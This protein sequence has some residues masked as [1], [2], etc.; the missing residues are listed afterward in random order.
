MDPGGVNLNGVFWPPVALDDAAEATGGQR[1]TPATWI[2]EPGGTLVKDF[3]KIFDDFRQG[4]VLR[5]TPTGVPLHGWHELNVALK[6]KGN[7]KV[8]ARRGYFG[9]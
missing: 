3:A 2:T 5:F 7:Y 6:L 8:R 1:H 4:Y 9:G